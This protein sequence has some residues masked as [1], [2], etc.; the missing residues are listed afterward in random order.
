MRRR[1]ILQ[2]AALAG[3]RALAA[4]VPSDVEVDRVLP[5]GVLPAGRSESRRYRVDATILVMSVPVFRRAGVGEGALSLRE[6]RDENSRRLVLEFSAASDPGR[7][8]GLDRMGWIREAIVEQQGRPVRTAM[9]GIMSESTE[10]NPNEARSA[11]HEGPGKRFVA[12]DS[13]SEPGATRT[14]LARVP[15]AAGALPDLAR[16]SFEPECLWRHSRWDTPH[17]APMSFLYS[18]LTALEGSSF[19]AESHYVYNEDLYRLHLERYAEARFVRYRAAVQDLTRNLPPFHFQFWLAPGRSS[20]LPVRIDFQPR[21]FLRLT[22]E[23]LD[24]RKETA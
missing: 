19:P 15:R 12:I 24:D 20:F 10:Q 7:A 17:F 3:L 21:S 16:A 11:L 5:G 6:S 8:N 13:C 9:L 1:D 22:L 14:R 2:L 18:I 23:A 4:A